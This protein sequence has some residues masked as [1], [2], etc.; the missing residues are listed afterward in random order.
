MKMTDQESES[1]DV[2][3][4][5]VPSYEPLIWAV[6]TGRDIGSYH[7][8]KDAWN[9]MGH[10]GDWD[11]KSIAFDDRG[12]LWGVRTN[13]EFGYWEFGKW[14]R[15]NNDAS[16]QMVNVAF[17]MFGMLANRKAD[18]GRILRDGNWESIKR[19]PEQHPLLCVAADPQNDIWGITK[20]DSVYRNMVRRYNR[21]TLEWDRQSQY[22][23]WDL[24]S[25]AFDPQGDMWC[26]GTE[27]NVGKWN[28]QTKRWDDKGRLGGWDLIWIAFQKG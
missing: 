27:H 18:V 15:F 28:T 19:Y 3:F 20:P 14:V 17:D 8:R 6:G 5:A 9:D 7:H 23:R 4:V 12:R 22:E 26:V 10:P 1:A 13:D 11:L 21:Q 16:Y 24:L 25:I 2:S